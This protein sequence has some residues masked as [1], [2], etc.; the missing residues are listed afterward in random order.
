MQEQS[1]WKF[2]TF[3]AYVYGNRQQDKRE[4]PDMLLWYPMLPADDGR[5]SVTFDAPYGASTYRVLIYANSPSGRLGFYE[6]K[7]EVRPPEPK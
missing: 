7:L 3:Q 4:Q 2:E 6:G 5:A 1:N